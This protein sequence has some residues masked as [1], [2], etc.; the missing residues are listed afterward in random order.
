MSTSESSETAD[1]VLDISE[2]ASAFQRYQV[3]A[4]DTAVAV[5]SGDVPVLGTPRMIAWCEAVT[6]AALA[7]ELQPTQ[8]SVGYRIRIDHLSP[9]PVGMSVDVTAAVDSVDG[10]QVTFS[11]DVT[12]DNG[13]AATGTITRVVVDRQRFID[14]ATQS[15]E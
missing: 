2:D 4:D 13:T 3:G 5:G 12:D 8:T 9:T 11:L 1:R 10:R 15:E 14:R 6:V 7:D